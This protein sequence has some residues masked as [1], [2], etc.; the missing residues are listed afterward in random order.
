[1]HVLLLNEPS[2]KQKSYFHRYSIDHED[3]VR[4][5]Q[6]RGKIEKIET[7]FCG[8]DL[9]RLRLSLRFPMIFSPSSSD[10]ERKDQ[11]SIRKYLEH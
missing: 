5:A 3:E 7:L 11:S 10:D 6:W 4:F 2:E 9:L 8:F 1:V